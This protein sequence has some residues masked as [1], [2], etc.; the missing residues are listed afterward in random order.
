MSPGPPSVYSTPLP[1]NRTHREG[2]LR[3]LQ[4]PNCE[5]SAS[6]P[7]V[8]TL[9]AYKTPPA[10]PPD[11]TARDLS[12]EELKR[13]YSCD[14]LW[15]FEEQP[16][17]PMPQMTGFGR[18]RRAVDASAQW[19]MEHLQRHLGDVGGVIVNALGD[20]PPIGLDSETW[21]QYRVQHSRANSSASSHSSGSGLPSG[22]ASD[23]LDVVTGTRISRGFCASNT[24]SAASSLK[25]GSGHF[26]RDSNLSKTS[27]TSPSSDGDAKRSHR[28]SRTSPYHASTT[29]MSHLTAISELQETT[30]NAPRKMEKPCVFYENANTEHALASDDDDDF[31]WADML[32]VGGGGGNSSNLTRRL[33]RTSSCK[34][35]PEMRPTLARQRTTS[36][37][38]PKPRSSKK[39]APDRSRTIRAPSR[40]NQRR[41]HFQKRHSNGDKSVLQEGS[42]QRNE[43]ES[44]RAASNVE[45]DAQDP[46]PQATHDH[47]QH[48]AVR[49]MGVATVQSAETISATPSPEQLLDNPTASL[50]SDTSGETLF[51]RGKGKAN[52]PP[53]RQLRQRSN[54]VRR[55]RVESPSECGRKTHETITE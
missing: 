41:P 51:A 3:S 30:A 55:V 42:P 34:A 20:C 47:L 43:K 45:D 31:D 27:M 53:A 29:S 1:E 54:T 44:E 11:I 5:R 10:G 15:N 50:R 39:L 7:A 2:S 26:R 33:E 24:S 6:T 32:E 23:Y 21:R 49:N 25:E 46:K 16:L 13:N 8:P 12:K 35:V 14:S 17:P 48:L 38:R 18:Y 40:P 4:R 9:T 37:E 28:S 52:D 22:G 36:S 19:R